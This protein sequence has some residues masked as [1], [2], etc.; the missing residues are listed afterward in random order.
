MNPT[1]SRKV[2]VNRVRRSTRRNNDNH[3]RCYYSVEL[4]HSGARLRQH[5]DNGRK[6]ARIGARIRR[7]AAP[8]DEVVGDC[9]GDGSGALARGLLNFDTVYRTR[10]ARVNEAHVCTRADLGQSVPNLTSRYLVGSNLLKTLLSFC[11]QCTCSNKI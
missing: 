4:Y 8:T 3:Y 7:G 11:V 2:F 9:H 1:N 10:K 6:H 5:D